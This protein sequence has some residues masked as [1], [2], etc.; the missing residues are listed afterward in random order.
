MLSVLNKNN[1]PLLGFIGSS[2]IA[3]VLAVI[4][5][6][7][8]LS[9]NASRS[10]AFCSVE[11]PVKL[12]TLPQGEITKTFKM[13]NEFD[14][15]IKITK[16]HSSC[17][18]TV[19]KTQVMDVAAGESTEISFTWTTTGKRGQS[20]V[21]IN[22]HYLVSGEQVIRHQNVLLSG[23]IEPLYEITPS[24]LHFQPDKQQAVKVRVTHRK[25]DRKLLVT[26]FSSNHPSI[27]LKLVDDSEFEV[28]FDPTL[29]VPTS[30]FDPYISVA[31][32]VP[33]EPLFKIPIHVE[34]LP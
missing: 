26:S 4:A 18:C 32:N 28:I 27:T 3:I 6:Q 34:R 25:P 15:P 29:W 31:V 10:K 14:K 1:L 19:A 9:Q 22:F 16:I 12:G 21:E 30:G 2:V 13:L 11:Q 7:H 23:D 8:A 24:R 5:L 33:S 20:S 17:S